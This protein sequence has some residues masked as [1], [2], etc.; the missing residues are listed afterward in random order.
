MKLVLDT[1]IFISAF[2]WGGNPRKIVERINGSIDLLYITNEIFDEITQVLARSKFN[3]DKTNIARLINAIKE[4]SVCITVEGVIKGVC[5]DSK[6]DIILECGWCCGADYVITGD[7]DLLSLKSF[8]GIEIITA[9][10]YL[11]DVKK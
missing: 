1:N 4:M 9:S 10:Q 2:F 7:D 5:R 8:R 3:V 6:D 11:N